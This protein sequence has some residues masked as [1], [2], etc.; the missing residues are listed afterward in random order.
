MNTL[1]LLFRAY[2]KECGA[3]DDQIIAVNLEDV[4]NEHL[5]DYRKLHE[6]VTG[7][8]AQMLSGD[9]ATLLSGRYVEICML[10][11]SFS[12]YHELVGGDKRGA[13][14]DAMLPVPL[15]TAIACI[16]RSGGDLSGWC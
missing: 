16:G 14:S 4:A 15:S 1:L 7:S 6:Y 8:I 12:E 11:L 10:P 3:E 13:W 9:L 5:L 2:L